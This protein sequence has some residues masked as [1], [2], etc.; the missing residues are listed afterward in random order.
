MESA[1]WLG[2]LRGWRVDVVTGKMEECN[3]P[4]LVKLLTDKQVDDLTQKGYLFPR[5]PPTCS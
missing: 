3:V 2:P 5:D 1:H 4:A